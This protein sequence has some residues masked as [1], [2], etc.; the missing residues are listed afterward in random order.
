M[1]FALHLRYG[2]MPPESFARALAQLGAQRVMTASVLRD[3]AKFVRA[4]REKGLSTT[5]SV[6]ISPEVLSESGDAA[7][8]DT[9]VRTLGINPADLTLEISAPPGP[10]SPQAFSENLAR[11]KLRGYRLAVDTTPAPMHFDHATHPHFSAIKLDSSL[12][13]KLATN[14]EVFKTVATTVNAA[15]RFGMT[16]CSRTT[17]D[18]NLTARAR[19]RPWSVRAIRRFAVRGRNPDMAGTRGQGAQLKQVALK[20]QRVG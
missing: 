17:D 12:V 11:L 20:R 4:M 1:P 18:V 9:Y 10:Q 16:A 14:P 13:C 2:E 6:N 19:N 5:V 3:A 15:H 8:L 7:S